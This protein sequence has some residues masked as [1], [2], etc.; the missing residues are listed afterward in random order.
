MK[1]ILIIRFSSIGDIVLT[2]PVARCVK[3]QV[4]DAEIHYCTKRQYSEVLRANPYIDKV[5]HLDSSLWKTAQQLRKE[6]VDF[7]VDL[8]KSLRSRLL[9]LLL[10]KP[11]DTFSKLN[12]KKWLLVRFRIN[13]LPDVHIV[14]RYFGA[15]KKLKVVTDGLGLDYF[16]PKQDE[17]DPAWLPVLHRQG[18]IGFVIGG[19]H[20]TKIFP[21]A[22]VI[23]VCRL[24][25]RPIVLLGGKDDV[26][27]AEE[28]CL[29]VGKKVYNACGQF[30]INKSAS[31]V[32]NANLIITND[33]GLMH[34][35]AAF[36]K[37]IISLWGNTVPVFGMYPY[38]AE[39]QKS[40]SVIFEITGLRC[41]PCSKIGFDKCPESHFDCMN[42]IG[43]EQ[44]VSEAIRLINTYYPGYTLT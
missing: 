24:L 28:I 3:Q 27:M 5:H 20:R 2:T 38:T 13:L 43:S 23:E 29:A 12:L 7:V 37:K 35:A 22:K 9:K 11:G 8:H 32:N 34:I 33:T 1:K 18:Y 4:A 17:F 6:N 14:D 39:Q 31:L 40:Q 19:R 41:R 44:L 36:G 10:C 15:V 25:D 42:K 21:T 30:S 16:L 26:A